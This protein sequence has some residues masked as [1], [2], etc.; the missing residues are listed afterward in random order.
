MKKA[1]SHNRLVWLVCANCGKERLVRL[2]HGK[3][4]AKVC[5]YCARHRTVGSVSASQMKPKVQ[6][7]GKPP[8]L[9]TCTNGSTGHWW[10]IESPNG[11][12]SQGV[13]KHCG[14]EKEFVNSQDLPWNKIAPSHGRMKAIG[15]MMP[16]SKLTH[17]EWLSSSQMMNRQQ[18]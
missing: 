16:R 12:T 6:R 4:R 3:P 15:L 13:C 1:R 14:A 11:S 5:A 10:I 9:S 7:I 18:R 17:L 8:T 2:E